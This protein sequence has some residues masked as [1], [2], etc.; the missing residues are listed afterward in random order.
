MKM[1]HH[2]SKK[3]LRKTT[4]FWYT[5]PGRV[6]LLCTLGAKCWWRGLKTAFSVK[7]NTRRGG[8]I[9]VKLLQGI[10]GLSYFSRWRVSR[11]V[12]WNDKEN[13]FSWHFTT[14]APYTFL[15]ATGMLKVTTWSLAAPPCNMTDEY[16][17]SIS[18]QE[19]CHLRYSTLELFTSPKMKNIKY[20]FLRLGTSG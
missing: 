5:G 9:V 10:C 13:L 1:K 20:I 16:V 18:V 11:L 12:R 19:L 8:S 17:P 7:A 14:V 3:A 15:T 6:Q 2:S 4:W